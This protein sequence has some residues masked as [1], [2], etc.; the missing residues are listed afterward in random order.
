[1][2]AF[3]LSE[4]AEIFRKDGY[5]YTIEQDGAVFNEGH[6]ML[7][8][9][10]FCVSD[11]HGEA[12][13]GSIEDLT[14]MLA[15]RVGLIGKKGSGKSWTARQL[16]PA[17]R[18]FSFAYKL[19]QVCNL[20][21]PGDYYSQEGK[22]EVVY[23]GL[24][25]RELL[26]GVGEALRSVISPRIWI[27][28]LDL[29]ETMFVVDDCR[30]ANEVAFLW[31][32]GVPVIRVLT[33]EEDNDDFHASETEMDNL[34]LPFVLNDG[35]TDMHIEMIKHIAKQGIRQSVEGIN[36]ENERRRFVAGAYYVALDTH[37]A[38]FKYDGEYF[39]E[40]L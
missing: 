36:F 27:D 1:M 39:V 11:S 32:K 29:P 10:G 22:K 16:V 14:D 31:S 24:T 9:E 26:Q 33:V 37:Y 40:A 20:L 34:E 21:F 38:M 3:T 28:V 4:A 30:M 12:I 8:K 5:R 6:D 18:V 25:R 19:K 35:Q 23:G 13:S 17:R 7:G 2:D 15:L